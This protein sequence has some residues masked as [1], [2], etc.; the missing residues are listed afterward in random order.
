MPRSVADQSVAELGGPV[1]VLTRQKKDHITLD[2]L[3]HDL[4]GTSGEDQ[5]AVLQRLYRLVFPHAF[6]EE[7]VLWP[8]MRRVL[9]DGQELTLEVEQ[10]HQ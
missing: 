2:R 8:T 5:D 9:P 6:A 1:S 4:H 7:S 10:E 3:L